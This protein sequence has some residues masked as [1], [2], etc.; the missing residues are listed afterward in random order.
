M[1]YLKTF[2]NNSEL[3]KYLL[4]KIIDEK[5]NMFLIICEVIEFLLILIIV[6]PEYA[7]ISYSCG[8]GDSSI[9]GNDNS[10]FIRFHQY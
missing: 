9:H 3:K 1:K 10:D 5:G 8:L 4:L 7:R 2:E 6:I